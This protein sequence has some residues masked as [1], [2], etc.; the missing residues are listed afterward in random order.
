MV[1]LNLLK[2]YESTWEDG[3]RIQACLSR[4]NSLESIRGNVTCRIILKKKKIYFYKKVFFQYKND[5]VLGQGKG[6]E[7]V[8]LI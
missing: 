5:A 1:G 4:L 7:R 2:N 3:I 6:M 8:A